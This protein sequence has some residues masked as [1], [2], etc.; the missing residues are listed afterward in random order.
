MPTIGVIDT[1]ANPTWVTYPIP[2]NDDSP[3][4]IALIGGVLGNAGKEGQ[5]LRKLKAAEDGQATYDVSVVKDKLFA[6]EQMAALDV[7]NS[8]GADAEKD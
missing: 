5:R 1:D 6:L 8:N 3:R 2:A 4:S 7:D